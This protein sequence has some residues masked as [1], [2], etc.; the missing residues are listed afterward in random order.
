MIA[1]I[2]ETSEEQ[3]HLPW[4]FS[5]NMGLKS[6]PS[7]SWGDGHSLVGGPPLDGSSSPLVHAPSS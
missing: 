5:P 1:T 4:A 3:G 6:L 7:A 2:V